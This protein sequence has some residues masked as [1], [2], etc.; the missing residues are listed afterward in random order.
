MVMTGIG[1]AYGI[2]VGVVTEL[3]G[4]SA[5]AVTE[6]SVWYDEVTSVKNCYRM[7]T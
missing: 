7:N 4:K 6:Y 3:N 1:T 2:T 5:F